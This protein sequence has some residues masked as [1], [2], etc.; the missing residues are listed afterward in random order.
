MRHRTK[1]ASLSAATV[2][3][4]TGAGAQ[5]AADGAGAETLEEIVVTAN[6]REQ[7]AR[8]V[9]GSLTALSAETIEARGIRGMRT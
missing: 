5:D 4:A 6:K 7:S 2:L 9:A 8:D 3:L 1:L